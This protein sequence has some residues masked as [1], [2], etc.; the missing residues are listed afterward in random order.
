MLLWRFATY[1]S[2]T[3]RTEVQDT[4]N[5]YDDYG[6]TAFQRA[7]AHLAVSTKTH[8]DE[9]HVK[10]IKGEKSLYEIR[11]KANN[12]ATRAL[13]FFGPQENYFTITQICYHK[14]NIYDPPGA[15]ETA[16]RKAEQIR[17]GSAHITPLQI[18]GEDFPPD[19]E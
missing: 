4:I 11:Y 5:R 16:A 6:S 1:V 12:R 7:V 14:Q 3:G 17:F 8:W 13:G 10:K 15:I 9:P 2:P 18:D 19:G